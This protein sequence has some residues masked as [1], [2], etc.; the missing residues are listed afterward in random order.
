M[1]KSYYKNYMWK[2][3]PGSDYYR[4]Q[5]EDPKVA[6]KIR[7]VKG[8]E[9]SLPKLV[10]DAI[11]AYHKVYEIRISSPKIALN[12]FKRVSSRKMEK[13]SERGLYCSK[14]PYI[15]HTK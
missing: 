4:F 3:Y 8:K 14:T 9:K 1:E 2:V 11:N 7:R 5:T 13:T 12:M 15:L 6:E 10:S